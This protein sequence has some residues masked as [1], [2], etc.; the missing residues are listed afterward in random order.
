MLVNFDQI[1]CVA[2]LGKKQCRILFWDRSDENCGCHGNQNI[3]TVL[4]P[5]FLIEPSSNFQ[6]TRTE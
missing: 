3:V 4:S 2:L 1:L 6:E 5:S